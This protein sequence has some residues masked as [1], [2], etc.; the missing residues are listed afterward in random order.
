[1][2]EHAELHLLL[3][4]C[5]PLSWLE[6]V[7]SYKDQQEKLSDKDLTTYG[8][9][10]YPLLQTA[11]IIIYKAGFVPVGE[12]QV[13]HV[14]LAR[15]VVR[16]F[17][18]IY[19]REQDFEKNIEAALKKM[20]K[21]TARLYDELRRSY[22]EQGDTSSLEK[23][24]EL[25][26]SQQNISIGDSERLSGY[27]DG[28]GK[29]IFPEPQALL[30]PASKMMGL[31]GQK[32]SKSY[33]NTISLRENPSVVEDKVKTMPTDPARIRLTDRGDPKKCPVWNLHEVYSDDSLKKW[34][35]EG[36]TNA[37]IGCLD[38]KKPLID[39]VL[40]EQAPIRER[41]NEYL[42]DPETVRGIITEGCDA[43]RDIAR[44]TLDDVR[45]AMGLSYS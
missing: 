1:M 42:N 13:S 9:L 36:C 14:E 40:K 11:D 41:A 39:A 15:E 30:T 12:D 33:G 35:V 18:H 20:G 24:R 28:S 17:N 38:C 19:G 5:T 45:E 8:F 27:L 16:R 31:D 34:V 25:L 22:Q 6:R 3:S 29:A 32:M 44:E 21:K 43:A 4:M 7:P 23:A 37:K 26:A 10:G 2:P